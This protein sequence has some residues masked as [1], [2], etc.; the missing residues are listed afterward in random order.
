MPEALKERQISILDAIIREYIRTARPVASQELVRHCRLGVSP[1]T[2]RNEM[3]ELDR[4]GYLEQPHT[5]A[6]RIPTDQGY[7]FFVDN[8][9]DGQRLSERETRLLN[10]LFTL[11]V[12][13]EF[14]KGFSR[15][16]ARL[17]QMFT[18]VGSL[19][20]EMF[21]PTGLTEVF[22]QP[23][24]QEPEVIREFGR[25][26]DILEEEIHGIAEELEREEDGDR[27]FIGHEN[28]WK[29]AQTYTTVVASWH[30]PR[31]FRG[32]VTMV[33]PRRANYPKL[34]AL[35]GRIKSISHG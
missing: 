20:D 11:N 19:E 9:L 16:V 4:E 23:E 28:P 5:S 35:V 22:E 10:E 18:A 3:L 17:S 29:K 12:E 2:I 13:E 31:G 14:M 21:Y 26:A 8:L 34:K 33:G 15:T 1:A 6:G 24:F 32:F 25:F 27:M 30:H 7:R